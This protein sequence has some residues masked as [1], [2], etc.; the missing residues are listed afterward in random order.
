MWKD[1]HS[2]MRT[3]KQKGRQKKVMY[4]LPKDILQKVEQ[5]YVEVDRESVISKLLS[6]WEANLSVG[7]EQL[8]RSILIVADGKFDTFESVFKSIFQGDPRDVILI[9]MEKSENKTHYGNRPFEE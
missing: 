3:I 4:T 8:A 2:T 5:T 9:A 7:A 6:L 1:N